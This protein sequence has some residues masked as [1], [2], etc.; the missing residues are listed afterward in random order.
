MPSSL[1]RVLVV[2]DEPRV[3]A[4]LS[5]VLVEL[6][7]MATVA[8]G[9]AEAL[10]LVPVFEP[11]VVLLDLLMPEMSGVEVLARLRR[12]YPTLRVVIMSGNEDV[13]VARATLRDGA[14]DYLSKPFDIHVLARVVAA[15]IAQPS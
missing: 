1:G 14:F 6:G 10:Q 7:Y 12:D 15:A 9:G 11:N 8:V 5:D 2:E 13:E 4:M 3:A